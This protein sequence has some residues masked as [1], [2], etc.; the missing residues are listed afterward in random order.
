MD[1]I[2]EN[3]KSALRSF[4]LEYS[5]SKDLRF[6]IRY[7]GDMCETLLDVDQYENQLK[8]FLQGKIKITVE[9]LNDDCTWRKEIVD[10]RGQK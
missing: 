3:V 8:L 10:Y 5:D 4:A 7:G 1:I 2:T 6:A 9:R